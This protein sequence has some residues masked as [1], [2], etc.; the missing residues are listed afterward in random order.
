MA[1]VILAQG[2]TG[3]EKKERKK[4][5]SSNYDRKKKGSALTFVRCV[6]SRGDTLVL[7]E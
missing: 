4:V 3:K 5:I 1:A 6:N 2:R 7:D